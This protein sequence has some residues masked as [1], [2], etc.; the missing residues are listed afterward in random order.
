MAALLLF[1]TSSFLGGLGGVLGSIIGHAAGRVGLWVGGVLGGVLGSIAGVAIARARG[2]V[3][4]AQFSWAAV[5]ASIGF[6]LAAAVAVRTLSS[7]VGPVLSTTLIGAG[8]LL[9]TFRRRTTGDH[10]DHAS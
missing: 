6:A 3:S 5:G 10:P 1:L 7:P 4:E 2:W 8:A 9:G